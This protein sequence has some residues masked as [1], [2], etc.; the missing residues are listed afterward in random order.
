MKLKIIITFIKATRKKIRNQN[1][2]DQIEKY[3]TVN[4]NWLMR[5]KAN[6]TLI[7]RTKK[8]QNQKNENQIG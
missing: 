6:K 3:N 4:L 5:L 7:K 8:N 1:N 2:D